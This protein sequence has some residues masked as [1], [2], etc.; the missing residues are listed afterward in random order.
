MACGYDP[1][2]TVRGEILHVRVYHETRTQRCAKARDPCQALHARAAKRAAKAAKRLCYTR[3][4]LAHRTRTAMRYTL[5][6][7]DDV[8]LECGTSRLRGSHIHARALCCALRSPCVHMI[9]WSSC[10]HSIQQ[11]R[12]PRWHLRRCHR[13]SHFA[14]GS[15]IRCRPTRLSMSTCD[16]LAIAQ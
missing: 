12:T 3:E 14:R 16:G 8:V 13:N 15:P 10:V 6:E 4:A 9:A 2:V 11:L 1:D 7:D 5:R